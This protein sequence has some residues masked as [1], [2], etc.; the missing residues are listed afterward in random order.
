MEVISLV[1]QSGTGKSHHAF[2]VLK[3]E[4][5]DAIIDDGLLIISG[6]VMAG[7]SAKR[8]STK[9]ASVR[10]A[11]FVDENHVNDV[12]L[13]IEKNEVK[14]ILLLG[15]SEAMTERVAGILGLGN[16]S[17]H[18]HIEDISSAE[19]I[20]IA[21]NLRMSQGKHI[22]PVPTFEIKK[23]FSGY[24]LHPLRIFKKRNGKKE[25][26]DTKSIVRPTYS[27]L[28]DY[29]IS[30]NA[31]IQM[32]MYESEKIKNVHKAFGVSVHNSYGVVEVNMNVS[33][34]YGCNI[35]NV[36]KDIIKEVKS[37]IEKM[38]A[39]NLCRVNIY[40]KELKV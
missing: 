35:K 32:V 30:D 9:L 28:G 36:C 3:K 21:R 6:K 15:T 33:L 12:K 10:R 24:F 29:T 19:D 40:V 5:A 31:I 7:K 17:K 37:R 27:Y 13:A 25:E 20:A 16:V 4:G 18:I 14:K 34:I 38:T 26:I 11:L 22:I 23:D 39:I 2:E 1:G 8:E